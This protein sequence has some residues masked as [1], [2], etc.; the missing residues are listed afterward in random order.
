MRSKKSN[1]YDVSL[2]NL[3]KSIIELDSSIIDVKLLH[4]DEYGGKN[5]DVKINPSLFSTNSLEYNK[6]LMSNNL[7]DFLEKK[8]YIVGKPIIDPYEY[9]MLDYGD[10]DDKEIKLTNHIRISTWTKVNADKYFKEMDKENEELKAKNKNKGI[11]KI[12]KLLKKQG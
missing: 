1:Q 4:E 3:L 9:D 6:L 7:V 12:W 5:F 11:R 8:G 2:T 10:R